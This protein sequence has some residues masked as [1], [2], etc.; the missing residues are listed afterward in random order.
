MDQ[1]SLIEYGRVSE[2]QIWNL[3][4]ELTFF[5]HVITIK[6]TDDLTT[7]V[8]K[9]Y[10]IMTVREAFAQFKI[11]YPNETIGSTSFSLLRPKHVLPMCEIPQNVCLCKY[12]TNIDLLLSSLYPIL[13]TPKTTRLFREVLVC[14]SDNERCMSSQCQICGNLKCFDDL[15]ECNDDVIGQYL[16]YFQWETI[17]SRIVKIEKS[18]TIQ[19]AINELKNQTPNFLM[20][21][22]ITHVQYLHFEECKENASPSSIVL[23]VDFSENYRTVYQD[24]QSMLV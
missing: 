8:Q 21:S 13:N 10:L 5:D 6:S 16:N 4:V 1:I 20:H 14:N 12:H 3:R 22:F 7:K 11:A 24:E 2:L 19:D 23:Q 9:R 15:F 18:G 17:N